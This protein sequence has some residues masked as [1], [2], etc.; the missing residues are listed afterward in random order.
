M[1]IEA[2]RTSQG[3][4]LMQ[5][6]YIIDLLTKVN[7]LAAKLVSTP[8]AM[9]LRLSLTSGSPLDYPHEYI[10]IIRSLQYLAF[11]KPD[12]AFKVNKIS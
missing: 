1:G 4:D 5:W 6:K 12:I 2:T 10:K 7:M 9:T 3:L 8:L 11:T